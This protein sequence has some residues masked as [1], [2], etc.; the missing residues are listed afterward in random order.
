[1]GIIKR[2]GIRKK[3]VHLIRVLKETNEFNVEQEKL[4]RWTMKGLAA[5]Q[6]NS[7][8]KPTLYYIIDD[9]ATI[10]PEIQTTAI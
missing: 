1:M 3:K 5:S 9:K 6:S 8:H 10:S 4:Q 7:Y 2:D